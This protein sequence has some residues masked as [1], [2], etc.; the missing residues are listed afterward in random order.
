MC[1]RDR[2]T[3]ANQ[4]LKRYGALKR[5]HWTAIMRSGLEPY[6]RRPVRDEEIAALITVWRHDDS[7]GMGGIAD[8]VMQEALARFRQDV[9]DPALQARARRRIAWQWYLGGR[10]FI[11]R[12]YRLEGMKYLARAARWRAGR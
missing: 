7:V 6:L 4:S 8:A 9:P 1:I 5:A 3:H 12:G 2:R 10:I 11:S